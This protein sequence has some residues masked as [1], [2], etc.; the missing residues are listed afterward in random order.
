MRMRDGDRK[1]KT[2][3]EKPE[4][5]P[6]KKRYNPDEGT[7]RAFKGGRKGDAKE[8]ICKKRYQQISVTA[9]GDVNATS[10]RILQTAPVYTMTL[11]VGTTDFSESAGV[12]TKLGG[13]ALAVFGLVF[14]S[15]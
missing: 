5:G 1:N 9:L 3:E 15:F 6:Q 2:V 7:Q 11:Q 4:R 14:F 10:G 12:L 13:L 8:N